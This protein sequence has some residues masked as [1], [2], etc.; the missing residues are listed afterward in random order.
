[1]AIISNYRA[2]YLKAV[3]KLLETLRLKG[4]GGLFQSKKTKKIEKLKETNILSV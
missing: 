3:E 4:I 1:M 2:I